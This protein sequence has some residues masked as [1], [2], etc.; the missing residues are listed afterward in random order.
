MQ[1]IYIYD[2]FPNSFAW[3][4]FADEFKPSTYPPKQPIIPEIMAL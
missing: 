2:I 1:R 4:L 3:I